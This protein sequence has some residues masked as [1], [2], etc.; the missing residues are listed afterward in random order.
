MQTKAPEV[1]VGNVEANLKKKGLWDASDDESEEEDNVKSL[2]KAFAPPMAKVEPPKNVNARQS[3]AVSTSD[4]SNDF[5]NSLANLLAKG[6]PLAAG[7][8]RR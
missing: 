3:A 4:E 7:A 2:P 8:P 1:P 5:K 6:N